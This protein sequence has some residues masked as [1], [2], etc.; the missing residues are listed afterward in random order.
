ML[1]K[2]PE[3]IHK[4]GGQVRTQFETLG[5]ALAFFNNHNPA[6][7]KS[8]NV[9]E[10]ERGGSNHYL[11]DFT[12]GSEADL[13]AA[14]LKC[15]QRA[16]FGVQRQAVEAWTLR[17]VGDR[18]H[19]LHPDEIAD[20]MRYSPRVVHRWLNDLDERAIIELVRRELLPAEELERARGLK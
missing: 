4:E 1:D 2:E 18:A 15:L 17:N 19:Q 20:I 12:G 6:R 14:V 16:F 11:D 13:W 7:Q 8:V 10:P 3:P 9:Y 5:A